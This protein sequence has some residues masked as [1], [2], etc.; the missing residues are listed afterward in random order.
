MKEE[1]EMEETIEK[2]SFTHRQLAVSCFNKVWDLLELKDRSSSETEE[3]IHL[4]HSSFWHWTKV[5]GHT[6]KNLS[7]GYWQLSRVY[8]VIGQ[9]S[10][11]LNY[12][13]KCK[14]IS[15]DAELEPFYIA[16]AYE[17]K[18]RAN[19]ILNQID[20]SLEA[21]NKAFEYASLVKDEE[22]KGWLLKDLE[23][24]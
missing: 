4:C 9:G 24:I 18:S 13:E 19:S 23:T 21:K 8:A 17:A 14:E 20:E 12:A 11:S 3:M 22:S 5:E 15:I 7:V 1:K 10:S 2:Q 16:Y 6:P